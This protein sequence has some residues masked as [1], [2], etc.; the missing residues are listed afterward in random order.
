MSQL[1]L[2]VVGSGDPL[3]DRIAEAARAAPDVDIVAGGGAA[4]ADAIL[5][6]AAGR[7]ELAA[8]AAAR[9]R[10]VLIPAPLTHDWNTWQRFARGQADRLGDILAFNELRGY[11]AL[12]S[13]RETAVTEAAG[14]LISIYVALRGRADTAVDLDALLFDAL[15]YVHWCAGASPGRVWATERWQPDAAVV[16]LTFDG[17]CKATVEVA[18]TLPA[19]FPQRRE[20]EVELICR[21]AVLRATPLDQAVTIYRPGGIEARPWLPDPA[22]TALAELRRAV[23][24]DRSGMRTVADDAAPLA[25]REAVH[26]SIRQRQ[27]VA[28]SPAEVAAE[29]A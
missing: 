2:A 23:A 3:G 28:L 12:A 10:P 24:G 8:E 6:A 4:E 1:R 18:K 7:V 25:A 14:P 26:R 9:G 20:I 21:D 22:E 19:S 27:A 29:R 5:I 16:H 13:A 11:A 15:D 17:N